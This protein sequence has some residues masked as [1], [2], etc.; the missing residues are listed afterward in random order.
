MNY[1][2]RAG[3]PYTYNAAWNP[4]ANG[5]D[6]YGYGVMNDWREERKIGV[7]KSRAQVSNMRGR[8]GRGNNNASLSQPRPGFRKDFQ[9]LERGQQGET[10]NVNSH[11]Q[12]SQQLNRQKYHQKQPQQKYQRGG[13]YRGGY[14]QKN[15]QGREHYQSNTRMNS[16]KTSF[17]GNQKGKN[18]EVEEKSGNQSAYFETNDRDKDYEELG[19]Q[20][21]GLDFI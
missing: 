6:R 18:G 8:G 19:E 3:Y 1:L 10:G 11:N 5:F 9:G 2:S 17:Q 15:Q 4:W 7:L 20:F 14:Q 13:S 12:Q 21:T 16:Q